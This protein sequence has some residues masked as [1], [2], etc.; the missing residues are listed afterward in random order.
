[1]AIHVAHE[2]MRAHLALLFAVTAR[3]QNACRGGRAAFDWLIYLRM[4]FHLRCNRVISGADFTWDRKAWRWIRH[5]AIICPIQTKF[6]PEDVSTYRHLRLTSNLC[7]RFERVLKKILLSFLS[8]TLSISPHQHGFLNRRYCLSN[9]LVFEETVMR[10]M[11]EGR[12][13]DVIYLDF[14]KAFDSVK[15]TCLLVKM[16]FFIIIWSFV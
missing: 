4:R 2:S 3:C 9:L 11:D 14:A 16:A 6:D 12:T 7:K 8:E 10:M 13:V 15:H 5:S 1:M